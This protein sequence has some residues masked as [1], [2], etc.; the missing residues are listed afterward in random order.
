VRRQ[1]WQN[2]FRADA[3][4]LLRNNSAHPTAP[5]AFE[6]KRSC[7]LQ[8]GRNCGAIAKANKAAILIDGSEYYLRLEQALRRATTSIL[9]IGWDFDGRIKLRP[10][11]ADCL[12]LGEFL[13]TLV[14]AR[15]DLQIRILIWSGA[16]VHGPGASL[17]L[18]MGQAW[19]DH[20]RITLKLD[21]H[22]PLYASLHQ[23]MITID[24]NIAFVGGMDLTI[25][26]W[27]TGDHAEANPYRTQPDGSSYPPVHDVQMV[28]DG[29]AATCID[30]TAR[31]RWRIATGEDI[32][33]LTVETP[34][35]P[36]DLVP[37]F[38]DIPVAIARTVPEWGDMVPVREIAALTEDMLG[39]A[40]H[41]IY[42]EAQYFTASNVRRFL[43][44]SLAAKDGPEIVAIVRRSSPGL[45]ERF[46]M[47]TNRDRFI[48]H[49]RRAD[50]HNRFRV[51]YP[52]V[53]GTDGPCEVL[54][55]SKVLIVDDALA[56][57]GSSNLSNRS[58]GLDTECDLAIEALDD[59]NRLRIA[60]WRN[61]LLAEHLDVTPEAVAA[62]LAK[63]KSLIRSIEALNH[64]ERGLRPF[65]E[66][67]LDGPTEPIAATRIM[68]P[69]RPLDLL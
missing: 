38:T 30:A 54:V 4:K 31:E 63:H 61:R 14:E 26:R 10:D 51:Y 21:R 16:V 5:A 36:P 32:A 42:I 33:A 8:A 56:R 45:L 28:V 65:A 62:A 68:D 7:V 35:W 18:L 29:E 43:T 57:I 44:N 64:G 58:V 50:R 49:I 11:S 27:D 13:R 55:H 60:G 24:G 3:I 37:D 39:S 17:P 52:V 1:G 41:T 15:P 9:I 66:V 25:R 40:K 48:R 20:P 53:K 12:P 2:P 47:G 34:A 59:T 67:K 46:V 23:K 69:S 19:Q 22:H 6:T